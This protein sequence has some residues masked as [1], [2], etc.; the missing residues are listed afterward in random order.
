VALD[1]Y[2]YEYVKKSKT[3]VARWTALI[4]KKLAEDAASKEDV[5]LEEQVDRSEGS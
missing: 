3:R 1:G 4:D 2:I 5:P